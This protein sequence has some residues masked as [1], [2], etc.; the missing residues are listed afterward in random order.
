MVAAASSEECG[1]KTVAQGRPRRQLQLRLSR[2]PGVGGR[3]AASDESFSFRGEPL[4]LLF[5]FGSDAA[6][7]CK[8]EDSKVEFLREM[9]SY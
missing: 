5:L 6:A 4:L 7:T 3:E 8:N 1:E 2:P 9:E